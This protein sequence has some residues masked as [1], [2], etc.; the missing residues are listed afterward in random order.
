MDKTPE[1]AP[2]TPA[3]DGEQKPGKPLMKYII[4]AAVV[5]VQIAA[6][7]FLQKAIF[8]AGP[9]TAETVAAEHREE[10]EDAE[11]DEHGEGGPHIVMLEEIVVNPAGTSG[12]RYLAI[13]MG[14]QTSVP[15]AEK[16]VEEAKPM[17]RDALIT[18]LS[19]KPLE[20]LANTGYR[21]SLKSE[22]KTT[23]NIVAKNLKVQN[24][25][26]SGY[27]LQ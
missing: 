14:I 27:V 20:Q 11:A 13:T 2:E 7:Y 23:L 1:P 17:I 12:R 4:I 8:F 3:P 24:I 10:G 19:A 18:L 22:V 26:F 25:V 9:A 5:L 21:D 16:K 6:A 15:E